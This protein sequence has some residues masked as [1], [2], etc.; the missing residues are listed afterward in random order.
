MNLQKLALGTAQFGMAYGIANRYGQVSLD[1]VRAILELA[2]KSGI[3]TLDTAISYG[4]SESCLGQVGVEGWQIITKLPPLSQQNIEGLTICQWV[5]NACLTSCNRL[6]VKQLYG[7]LLHR[8]QD[9]LEPR[10]AELYEALR[11]VKA[12]GWVQKIGVS[13]YSPEELEQI[14]HRFPVAL[15]QAPFNGLDRRLKKSGWLTKLKEDGVEVHA[16]SIFLQGLLLLSPET[17]PRQFDRW[18]NLWQELGTWMQQAGISPLQA[19]LGAVFHEPW[20]DRILIGV[21]SVQQLQEILS[22]LQARL[23]HWPEELSFDDLDLID[24][25]HWKR[26]E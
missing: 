3:T 1:E 22:T 2:Y 10:G 24:P 18:S 4:D 15:V 8:S 23:P 7:L 6:K 17:R 16:R 12:A 19:C 5:K 20:F 26:L 21:D 9:L 14:Y 13:I 25:R 11:A